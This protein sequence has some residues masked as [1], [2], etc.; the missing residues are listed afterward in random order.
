MQVGVARKD[1][2]HALKFTDRVDGDRSVCDLL[3]YA[4][5]LFS[6]RSQGVLPDLPMFFIL[7]LAG[8]SPL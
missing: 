6:R 1:F 3:Y 8:F 5:L 2:Q 4:A 7:F